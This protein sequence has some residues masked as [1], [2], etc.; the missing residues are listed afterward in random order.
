MKSLSTEKFIPR[1][2]H[3]I[4]MSPKEDGVPTEIPQPWKDWNRACQLLHPDWTYI[5]WNERTMRDFIHR[6]MPQLLDTYDTYPSWIQRCDAFRYIVLYRMGGVYLDMDVKCLD[7][8]DEL[9][10]NNHCI[11]NQPWSNHFMAAKPGHHLLKKCV[12]SLSRHKG[13]SNVYSS[14]GPDFLHQ[15]YKELL[16]KERIDLIPESYLPVKHVSGKTWWKT[17]MVLWIKK[18]WWLLLLLL[19]LPLLWWLFW[20]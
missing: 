13:S 4:W 8:L 15:C 2:I 16:N 1:I 6:E 10:R 18:Y 11:L 5:I 17:Q 20:R 3:K 19:L 14:T 9:V 7:S 12:D